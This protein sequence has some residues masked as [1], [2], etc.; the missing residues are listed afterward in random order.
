M[1]LDSLYLAGQSL[2][3]RL[4]DDAMEA[5]LTIPAGYAPTELEIDELL[6]RNGVTEG[7]DLDLVTRLAR[8]PIPGDHVVAR[9]TPPEPTID[10]EVVLAFDPNPVPQPRI[11]DDGRANYF[12]LGGIPCCEKGDVIARKRPGRQGAA[13]RTVKGDYLEAPVP[14]DPPL[15]AGA[16]TILVE[17]EEGLA[18]VA[19]KAGQPVKRGSLV[20]VKDLFVV[21]GDLDVSVGNI[22]HN[23]SV[24]VR[25]KIAEQLVLRAKGDITIEGNVETATV[26]CGG[27]LTVKGGVLRESKV[28]VNGSLRTRFIERSQVQVEQHLF[29]QEDI[30]FSEVEVGGNI[31]V[32]SGVVGGKVQAAGY[33]RASY[34]GKRLGTATTIEVGNLAAWQARLK[35]AEARLAEAQEQLIGAMQPLQEL[36]V[37]EAQGALDDR[38]RATKEKLERSVDQAR[39]NIADRLKATLR[40]KNLIQGLPIPR[41]LTP[42]GVIHPGVQVTIRNASF[43]AE[44]TTRASQLSEHRGEIEIY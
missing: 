1:D 20:M 21:P 6:R 37:L 25:G 11:E 40:L 5:V 8:D 4:S 26:V 43:K 23:G 31:E 10:G 22:E 12:D 41:V 32:Q 44:T 9:G 14:R 18:I 13:G 15:L 17:D 30:L 7:V 27:D 2:A 38:G 39:Q 29:V 42:G 3:L 34:L 33:L 19:E 35:A 24:L 16:N 28:V 36:L